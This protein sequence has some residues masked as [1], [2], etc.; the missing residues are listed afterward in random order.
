M[1]IHNR[2]RAHTHTTYKP[3]QNRFTG[4]RRGPVFFLLFFFAL[5]EGERHGSKWGDWH[6]I[7]PFYVENM[8]SLSPC[9]NPPAPVGHR[10]FLKNGWVIWIT[11]FMGTWAGCWSL[12]SFYPMG[13]ASLPEPS[14]PLVVTVVVPKGNAS[15]LHLPDS[16]PFLIRVPL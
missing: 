7:C 8:H 4:T 9:A 2:A 13:Q 10:W 6:Q 1:H 11:F 3:S 5:L 15:F 12:S 14:C 16:V